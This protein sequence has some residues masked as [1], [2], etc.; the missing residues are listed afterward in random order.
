M[1]SEFSVEAGEL[2]ASLKIKRSVVAKNYRPIIDSLY[3]NT[4]E[5]SLRPA[6][7]A[8]AAQQDLRE[9]VPV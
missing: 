1:S 9:V 2:T 8:R 5:P 4:Y 6:A 3:A 7:Q